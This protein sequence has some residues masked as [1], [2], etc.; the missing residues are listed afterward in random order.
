MPI[1]ARLYADVRMEKRRPSSDITGLECFF[2]FLR[3][4]IG[5]C[6]FTSNKLDWRPRLRAS[7]NEPLAGR[8]QAAL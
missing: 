1:Y 8:T 7:K 3:S 5:V 6:G 4:T 2:L